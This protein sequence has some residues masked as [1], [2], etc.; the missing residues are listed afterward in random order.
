MNSYINTSS[1]I[2]KELNWNNHLC[3]FY[4]TEEQLLNFLIPFFKEGLENNQ[5]CI[6][7]ISNSITEK[8]AIKLLVNRKR[9]FKS[10][11]ESNQLE[12]VNFQDCY[13]E[14]GKINFH[15]PFKFSKKILKNTKKYGFEGARVSG[16]TKWLS[17]KYLNKFIEFETKIDKKIKN[18]QLLVA[19]TY[20]INKFIKS[21]ILAIANVHDFTVF[22]KNGTYKV[23]KSNERERLEQ[24][25]RKI[26]V[27]LENLEK[28]NNVGVLTSSIA[29][30]FNNLLTLIKGYADMAQMNI[31]ND[32]KTNNYLQ[33]IS[34]SIK[35]AAK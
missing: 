35:G 26:N 28:I 18:Q 34:K 2:V 24:E 16:D 12:I 25:K 11:H 9:N 27:Q 21:D 1:E 19:C 8:K 10:L 15:K 3:Y 6:W 29:H 33:E 23:I 31:E 30:D 32:Q 5:Y 13:Y 7:I 20:P 4:Y 14:D 17:K 22:A